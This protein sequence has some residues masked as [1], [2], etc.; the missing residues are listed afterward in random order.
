MLPSATVRNNYTGN[1]TTATYDYTFKIFA[2]TQ[3][4][5]WVQLSSGVMT[6]LTLNTDY[7][8][9]GAGDESGGSIELI[10][11]NQ[12]WIDPSGYLLGGVIMTIIRNMPLTQDTD[13]R[14]QGDFYP[15]TIEDEFDTIT[16]QMQM[17]GDELSRTVQVQLTDS[18]GSPLILPTTAQRANMLFGFDSSGNPTA[19]AAQ[20]NQALVSS[21]VQSLLNLG[22]ATAFLNALGF[23]SGLVGTSNIAAA[24][25]TAA[26]L[27]S[28]AAIS[29]IGAGGVLAANLAAGAALSNIGAGNVAAS[30][31]AASARQLQSQVITSG[32]TWTS[33]ST[34]TTS[35]LLKITLVGGGGGGGGVSSA[36]DAVAGGGAGGSIGILYVSGLSPSIAY[37]ITI[38]AFGAGGANTGANGG[39]GGQTSIIIGATTYTA[40]GGSGGTGSTAAAAAAAPGGAVGNAATNCTINAS[41]EGGGIGLSISGTVGVSGKGGN[42]FSPGAPGSS[43]AATVG[44]SPSGIG[45]GGS[46]ACGLGTAKAGGGAA[47]GAIIIEW[48][49]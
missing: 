49:Q 19:I 33:P 17:L 14:N 31:I 6:Q 21:Y 26:L 20:L 13:V 2:V 40:A 35:T 37:T 7:S 42:S 24:N 46:G 29:N 1:D 38:G 28:G 9:S 41:G 12:A 22:G 3:L 48:V 34:I 32:T 23:T 10:A 18:V 25:I 27:A 11:A 30:Y 36:A 45:G 15:D 39:N 4:A 5:V 8:V 44:Q 43:V 47:P 16:M